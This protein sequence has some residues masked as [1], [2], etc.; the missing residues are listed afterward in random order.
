MLLTEFLAH[1]FRLIF[2]GRFRYQNRCFA[3]VLLYN[4]MSLIEAIFQHAHP[5]N[6]GRAMYTGLRWYIDHYNHRA[7]QG[8][9]R[10]SPIEL[11]KK[12]A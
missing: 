5:M 6:D 2:F 4:S 8:I 12:S 1:V 10:I 7:H 3:T 9:G 11:Y